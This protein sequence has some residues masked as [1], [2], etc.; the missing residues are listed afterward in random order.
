LGTVGGQTIGVPDIHE[1][2]RGGIVTGPT[3]ALIGERG[4]EAVIPLSRMTGGG[5]T[6]I[7]VNVTT[8]GL[9]A[10]NPAIQSAVV[11][12]LRGYV[13]RNG[14]VTELAR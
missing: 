7:V 13:G 11:A 10:D 12:A 1:L 3:L 4:P 5:G 8:T 9:G 2:A 6:T 14:P